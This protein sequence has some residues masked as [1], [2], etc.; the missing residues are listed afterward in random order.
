HNFTLIHDDIMD[1]APLRR[2]QTTVHEKW[3]SDIAV[4]SGD[5][6]MIKSFQYLG[7]IESVLLPEAFEVFNKAAVDICEGQQM[8][9]DFQSRNDVTVHEYIEM[10]RLK[11]AVLLGT[12]L[13][14]G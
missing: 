11:T 9:M 13:N 14:L 4:L 5:V 10:I 12:A 2:N 3:N 1:Q 6:L 7:N 8:D